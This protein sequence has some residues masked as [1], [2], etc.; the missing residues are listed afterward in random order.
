MASTPCAEVGWSDSKYEQERIIQQ[1][2]HGDATNVTNV[3]DRYCGNQP[4]HKSIHMRA[5]LNI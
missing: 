2:E 1:Q 4:F 5:L 3:I